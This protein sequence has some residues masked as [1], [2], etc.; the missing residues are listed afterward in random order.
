MSTVWADPVFIQQPPLPSS[1]LLSTRRGTAL[2]A[3]AAKRFS[4]EF[5]HGD[6]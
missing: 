6:V 1:P 2:L 5:I 4:A 3:S